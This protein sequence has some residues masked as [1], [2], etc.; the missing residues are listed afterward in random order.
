MNSLSPFNFFKC[1]FFFK[2]SKEFTLDYLRFGDLV[3]FNILNIQNGKHNADHGRDFHPLAD[4]MT[5]L[6]NFTGEILAFP[7]SLQLMFQRLSNLIVCLMISQ[8]LHTKLEHMSCHVAVDT[9]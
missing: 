2:S 5:K 1:V 7:F 8:K 4:H 6:R 3:A 9:R